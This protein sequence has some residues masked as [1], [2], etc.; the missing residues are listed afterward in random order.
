MSSDPKDQ[1]VDVPFSLSCCEC[2]AESPATLDEAQATGW[3]GIQYAPDLPM[4]NFVGY[5]PTHSTE[6]P[7]NS[8]KK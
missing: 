2:D 5:C 6:M 8:A 1:P 7:A 4:A 3:T